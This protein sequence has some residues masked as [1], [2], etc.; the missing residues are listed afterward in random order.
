MKWTAVGASKHFNKE[1]NV[2]REKWLVQIWYQNGSVK[3]TWAGL[4][5]L[6]RSGARE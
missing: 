2:K 6:S 3:R 1:G 4:W 5:P